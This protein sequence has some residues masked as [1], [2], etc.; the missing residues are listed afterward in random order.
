MPNYEFLCEDCGS[1]EER[2]S[3]AEAD[4][5][6]MCPSCGE[7]ARRIYSMPNSRRVPTALSNAM[8]RAEKSAH[9]PE[10]VRHPAGRTLPGKK[11]QPSNGGHCVHNH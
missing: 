7:E 9:E 2:R 8:H 4:D 10:M 3:L 6:M 1:F 11:Y 5:P